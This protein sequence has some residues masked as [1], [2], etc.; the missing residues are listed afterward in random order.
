MSHHEGPDISYCLYDVFDL[1]ECGPCRAPQRALLKLVSWYFVGSLM[2]DTLLIRCLRV[3]L[4][5]I[6][7]DKPCA[8]S[9]DLCVAR[10]GIG[11]CSDAHLV[12]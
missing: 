8:S 3:R 4:H 7:D 11:T 9:E 2:T 5:P 10:V 12:C 1:L 6:A